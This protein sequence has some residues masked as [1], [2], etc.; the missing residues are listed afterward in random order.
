MFG[1]GKSAVDVTTANKMSSEDGYV[2]V[3]VRT[4]GERAAGH[5]PGSVHM[6]L[7][8]IPERLDELRGTKVLAFCRSGNRSDAATKFLNQN[9]IEAHNIKGGILAW[10]RA[11]LPLKKGS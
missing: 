4:D 2:I 11:G 3:D 1:R 5:P 8:T 6:V 7:E 9:D 10:T